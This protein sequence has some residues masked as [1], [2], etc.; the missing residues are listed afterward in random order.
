[1]QI[2]D[3]K[4]N[5]ASYEK[6]NK[7]HNISLIRLKRTLLKCILFKHNST[8]LNKNTKISVTYITKIR[9]FLYF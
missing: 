4:F 2:N 9:Y 5:Q 3:F 8:S 6:N 1:M 7:L